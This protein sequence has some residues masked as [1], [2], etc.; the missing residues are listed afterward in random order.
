LTHK[1]VR[2]KTLNR[3]KHRK[4]YSQSNKKII[5]RLDTNK[6]NE[7][8]NPVKKTSYL[9]QIKNIKLK[10]EEN[11]IRLKESKVIESAN[12]SVS[13]DSEESVKFK[14]NQ[15]VEVFV[16]IR[17]FMKFEFR[18]KHKSKCI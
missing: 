1:K 17:P 11:K 8:I 7:T 15:F 16:R 12:N 6:E 9:P 18:D 4:K 13:E 14:K 3:S 2:K 10:I 5:S